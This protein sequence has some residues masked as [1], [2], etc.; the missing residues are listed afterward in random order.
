[1]V[2]ARMQSAKDDPRF[3]LWR[4]SAEGGEPQELGLGM[5]NFENLSAHPDGV[6]LAFS[7]LGPTMK[8]P[9]VWV[10]ENFLPLARTP[11]R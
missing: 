5:A 1:I 7:S 10:M 11:G 8:L 9:S 3:S 2:F 4:V 6:R